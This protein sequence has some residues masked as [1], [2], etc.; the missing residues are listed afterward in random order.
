MYFE[1]TGMQ[2]SES[3]N[4]VG[5][6]VQ[7]TTGDAHS[8]K[9]RQ[10]ILR[11]GAELLS[12]SFIGIAH[13][14]TRLEKY[15]VLAYLYRSRRMTHPD[16]AL[17]AFSEVI[18]YL[19]EIEYSKGFIWGLPL[20]DLNW[21]LLWSAKDPSVKRPSFPTW[22]WAAWGPPLGPAATSFNP[23]RPHCFP[24]YLKVWRLDFK[25]KQLGLI[26]SLPCIADSNTDQANAFSKG[27]PFTYF[28]ESNSSN[29]DFDLSPI[30]TSESHKYLFIHGIMFQLVLDCN[31]PRGR[32]CDFYIFERYDMFIANINCLVTIVATDPIVEEAALQ[33]PET[34]LLVARNQTN[35]WMYLHLLVLCQKGVISQR[36]SVI[37]LRI[38]KDRPHVLKHLG[39]R[40]EKVILG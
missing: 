16:D 28:M 19:T 22:S 12:S 39:I 20:E 4:E 2:G 27:D 32:K 21:A 37:T 7:Q 23:K 6:W 17:N 14:D 40:R 3:L 15:T 8:P 5:S 34:F 24:V 38:P 26:L 31:S 35:N 10:L 11:M 9:D 18:Q 33:N 25:P 13:E 1:C 30:S 29:A 36:K